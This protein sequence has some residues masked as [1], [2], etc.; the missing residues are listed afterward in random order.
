MDV[1][2]LL[3]AKGIDY[4]HIGANEI[5]ITCPNAANHS[6]GFD[7]K[8]SFNINTEKLVGNCLACGYKAS[9]EGLTRWLQGDNLDEFQ[10]EALSIKGRLKKLVDRQAE[11][12]LLRQDE[13]F[14]LVPPS[15]PW[16]QNYR[17]ISAE[18]YEKLDARHCT[19][20]R[21]A[22]R[23]FFK[24]YQHGKLLGI[25]ARALKPEMSPKYLRNKGCKAGDWL[26]P[27]DYWKPRNPEYV[28]IA[29]GCYHAVNG[30]QNDIPILCMYGTNNFTPGN[31]VELINLNVKYVVYFGDNDVAG[32]KARKEICPQ[33]N[34]WI[35]TYY[36]PE[37][38]LP[39]GKDAGDLT[40]EEME[41]CL[42]NKVRFR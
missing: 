19:V 30:V 33:I 13:E 24:I 28:C 15:A 17:G 39:E 18:T 10:I 29:E 20:G 37:E 9:T 11:L 41:Y 2:G 14:T 21:Y 5:A 31:I 35:P 26:W 40:K 23:I 42:A 1:L 25:D 6:G 8:P 27:L 32:I 36:V 16:R 12:N 3:E 4:I 22:D 34:D 7:S 38:L